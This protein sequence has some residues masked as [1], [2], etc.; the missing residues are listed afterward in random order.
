[1]NFTT[2]ALQ[3]MDERNFSKTMILESIDTIYKFGK[4]NDRIDQITLN[5]NSEDMHK[6]ILSKRERLQSL[7]RALTHCAKEELTKLKSML[8]E[9]KK[10]LKAFEKLEHKKSITLVIEEDTLI[11]VYQKQKRLKNGSKSPITPV[12]INMA[13]R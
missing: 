1:M 2:H 8:K 5:T 7:K 4:W 12:F 11:T 3:R 6:I 10:S 13:D 9:C